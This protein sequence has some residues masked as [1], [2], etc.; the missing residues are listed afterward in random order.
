MKYQKC[1]GIA[2]LMS[3]LLVSTAAQAQTTR[4][5]DD[6]FSTGVDA[7]AA[8]IALGVTDAHW[9]VQESA[10]GWLDALYEKTNYCGSCGG[11]WVDHPAGDNAR[12]RP[13]AHP[14]QLQSSPTNR[15][16]SWRTSFTLPAHADPATATITYRVGYDDYSRNSAD[17]ANLSGCEHVVWLNG[18]AYEM[19]ASA[20]GNNLQTTCKATIPAGSAFVNGT[21]TLEFRI[22]NGPTYYGFRFEKLKAAY[23]CGA[24]TGAA[25][26]CTQDM[27]VS[28]GDGV[29][30][31]GESCDDG[32][33]AS[34]DGCSDT[35]TVEDGYM[36]AGEP[37]ECTQ[38][39]TAKCGDGVIQA[40]ETCDDANVVAGDGCSDTCQIEAGYSCA[41]E[42]SE[43]AQ[44]AKCGDG[45]IQEGEGCDDSNVTPGDG[46]SDTCTIEDGYMCVG[47]PSSCDLIPGGDE[48][49]DGTIG[50]GEGCD[51]GNTA[52]GDGCSA[53]CAI[54]S[55]WI[56]KGEPSS[57]DLDPNAGEAKCGDGVIQ[58][59][60]GCDDANV[61]A[62]D[63]CSATCQVEAGFMCTGEPS[64]CDKI[65]NG[66]GNNPTTNTE[67]SCASTAPTTPAPVGAGLLGLLGLA[68]VVRRRRG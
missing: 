65:T 30:S 12:S 40:G 44:T 63:G 24:G 19:A 20:G 11:V 16:F 28:C 51:D 59:G 34:G 58:A 25:S 46:C 45:V 29:I 55:G 38:T 43:C 1:M 14:N 37:S 27:T 33:M 22:G 64:A 23:L 52:D 57:C 15:T 56:C 35:C 4:P 3:M 47:E 21:N 6:L 41:G 48:C 66:N 50:A 53:S 32:N 61:S 18:T 54:E 8:P 67:E 9:E 17:S 31:E 5:I 13:L 49:G 39:A 7:A 26:A 62:G 10:L 42:P 36:C 68:L 2:A 60:E